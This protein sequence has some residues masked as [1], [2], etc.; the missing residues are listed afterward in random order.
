MMS[1]NVIQIKKVFKNDTNCNSIEYHLINSD[2]V[3]LL[4]MILNKSDVIGNDTIIIGKV[5]RLIDD[6]GKHRW[7][8]MIGRSVKYYLGRYDKIEEAEEKCDKYLSKFYQLNI[9]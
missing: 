2:L 7:Q 4:A 3:G 8:A 1:D 5:V 6:D 9:H